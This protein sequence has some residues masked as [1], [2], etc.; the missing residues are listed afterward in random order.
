MSTLISDN[1]SHL[2]LI[3]D[4]LELLTSTKKHITRTISELK[5][6]PYLANEVTHFINSM[7]K[8]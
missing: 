1:W 4:E 5:N 6:K 2:S 3:E 8:E 7:T